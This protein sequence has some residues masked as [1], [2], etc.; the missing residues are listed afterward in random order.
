MLDVRADVSDALM[1]L[2]EV[3][4]IAWDWIEDE[5]RSLSKWRYADSVADYLDK[6]VDLA[7]IDAVRELLE[8]MAD[9]PSADSS[10]P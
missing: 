4:L 8:L 7:R 6:T 10:A 2:R 3:N 1:H 5:T 9:P